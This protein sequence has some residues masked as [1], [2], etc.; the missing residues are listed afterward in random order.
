MGRWG[1]EDAEDG[2]GAGQV[3]GL[4][5]GHQSHLD[6]CADFSPLLALMLYPRHASWLCPASSSCLGCQ[7]L[8]PSW[9]HLGEK[10]GLGIRTIFLGPFYFHKSFKG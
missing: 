5:C 4:R 8:S 7:D 6:I 2:L 9:V 10:S 3:L 1:E